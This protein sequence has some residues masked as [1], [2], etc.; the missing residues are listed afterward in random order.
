MDDRTL[1]C[2]LAVAD[3]GSLRAAARTL[4]V[5]PSIIQRTIAAAERSLGGLLFERG[6]SGSRITDLGSVVLRHAHERR[7]LEAL[8]ADEVARAHTAA[9]GEV[10]VGIGLGYLDDIGEAVLGPFH[11]EHPEVTLRVLSGGTDSMVSALAED[12]ADVAIALHPSPHPE[13]EV[14]R[15]GPQ[16]VGVAC[17]ADHPLARAHRRADTLSPSDLDQQRFAVMLPGFGLRALHDE[18]TRV[19]GVHSRLAVETDSQAVLIAAVARGQ[20]VSLVPPVFLTPAPAG[21]EIQLL[22]VDDSHLR[23]VREALMIRR[24]RRLPPAAQALLES[25]IAWMDS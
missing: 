9:V 12:T 17:N 7:D 23:Q 5:A 6:A 1:R 15:S 13:V 10:R 20:V 24:G 21:S 8:F 16:P 19:H 25:C 11:R 4:D 22:D 14:V 2:V 3:A 18:F